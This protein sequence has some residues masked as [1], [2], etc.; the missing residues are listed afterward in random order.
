MSQDRGRPEMLPIMRKAIRAMQELRYTGTREVQFRKGAE[1]KR[2]M[3][4][5]IRDG[6]NSRTEFPPGS[7]FAGQVIVETGRERYHYFPDLKE[8]HVQP[9]RRKEMMS[10]LFDIKFMRGRDKG[11]KLST[12]QGPVVAGIRTEQVVFSTGSGSVIQRVHIDPRSGVVLKREMFDHA[13]APVGGFEFTRI[14]LNPPPFDPRI[15]RIHVPGAKWLRQEDLAARLSKQNGFLFL[16]FPG[17]EQLVLE[18]SRLFDIER[19][20]VLAQM[21]N[22]PKGRISL[23]QI[24]GDIEPQRLRRFARGE[25][26][27][28]AWKFQGRNFVL[29]GEQ[30]AAEL[31][32]L[33]KRLTER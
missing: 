27:T 25:F 18:N 22:S 9:A 24:K 26:N 12:A 1:A 15:F 16:T 23:F 33:A 17:S 32:R 20:P 4:Q 28:H 21:Y 7:P 8:V 29:V 31:Q 3:E 10:R 5:V 6:P 30:D 2:H 13:G 14:N 19:I 11:V